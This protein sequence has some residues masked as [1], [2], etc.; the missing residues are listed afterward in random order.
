MW[1]ISD[2]TAFR[3]DYPEWALR[4]DVPAILEDIYQSNADRWLTA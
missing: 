3:S 2:L 1:W 4:Y